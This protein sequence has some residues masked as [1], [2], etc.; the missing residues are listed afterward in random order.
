MNYSRL[1]NSS[2]LIFK[3]WMIPRNV[4]RFNSP[5]CMG[6]TTHADPTPTT[7]FR[8]EQADSHFPIRSCES[9]GLRSEKSLFSLS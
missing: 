1:P 9:F 5:L 2:T 4:L 3:S 6:I 8:T 7:S